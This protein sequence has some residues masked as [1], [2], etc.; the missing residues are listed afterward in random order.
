[1]VVVSGDGLSGRTLQY[2]TACSRRRHRH[3]HVG[4][5]SPV[6]LAFFCPVGLHLSLRFPLLGA[7]LGRAVDHVDY[8]GRTQRTGFDGERRKGHHEVAKK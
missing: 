4:V 2:M 3:R 7:G 6:E 8:L 1:M 5:N